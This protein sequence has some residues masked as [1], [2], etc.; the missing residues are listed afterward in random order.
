MG[1]VGSTK[2]V[3]F[4]PW[5][6]PVHLGTS[7]RARVGPPNAPGESEQNTRITDRKTVISLILAPPAAFSRKCDLS[8]L[9]KRFSQTLRN[10]Q[11]AFLTGGSN[12]TISTINSVWRPLSIEK[13]TFAKS[14]VFNQ[15][16]DAP[17]FF[18]QKIKK[19]TTFFE[20]L[21]LSANAYRDSS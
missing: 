12:A 21:T 4:D 14:C 18:E 5:V 7:R 16:Q 6:H 15:F 1:G 8:L 20:K 19:N 11:N 2:I 17:C 13:S 3:L 10:W 9:R